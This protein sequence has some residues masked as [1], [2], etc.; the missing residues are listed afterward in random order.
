M[1]TA[2]VSGSMPPG[3]PPASRLLSGPLGQRALPHARPCR[4]ATR[5]TPRCGCAARGCPAGA[6]W[7]RGRGRGH[8]STSSPTA[9]PKRPFRCLSRDALPSLGRVLQTRAG[10][11]VFEA[12]TGA[13][14]EAAVAT[15][16]YPGVVAGTG[17]LIWTTRRR[18]AHDELVRACSGREEA[19]PVGSTRGWWQPTISVL[20]K[21]RRNVASLARSKATR[22]S[23]A[24]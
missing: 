22:P 18:P 9:C 14:V 15:R 13:V 10:C 1:S 16:F 2:P 6:G 5:R 23:G 21:Q 20:R 19:S 12:V 3:E 17:T 24:V 11:A 4:A 8:S 7:P